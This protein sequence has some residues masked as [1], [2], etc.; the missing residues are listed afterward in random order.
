[1][2]EFEFEGGWSNWERH[3][4]SSELIYLLSGAADLT[5]DDGSADGSRTVKLRGKGLVVVP[6][7][8]WH[9]ATAMERSTML[10]ITLGRG[11]EHKPRMIDK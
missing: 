10:V 7:N 1:M 3:P 4:H 8:T 2:T 11:T 6:P 5:L 9:T